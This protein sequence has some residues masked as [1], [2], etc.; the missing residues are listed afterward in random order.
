M[1]IGQIKAEIRRIEKTITA[2]KSQARNH[3]FQSEKEKTHTELRDLN[4][5]L[6]KLKRQLKAK[7]RQMKTK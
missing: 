2:K 5:E 4:S 1:D 6:S 7:H 3:L